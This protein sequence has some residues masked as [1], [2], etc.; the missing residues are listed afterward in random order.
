MTRTKGIL[1]L[2]KTESESQSYEYMFHVRRVLENWS[3]LSDRPIHLEN[4][5]VV[6]SGLRHLPDSFFG[7]NIH[8]FVQM[9]RRLNCAKR[10]PIKL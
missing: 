2:A 9:E 3:L 10:S 6:T 8:A 4:F 1:A 7:K 5:S